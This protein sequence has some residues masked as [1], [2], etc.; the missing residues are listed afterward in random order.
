MKF[1]LQYL[2]I[3]T[4]ILTSCTKNKNEIKVQPLHNPVTILG[5]QYGTVTIGKLTWTTENYNGASGMN[6]A[7]SSKNDPVYG[8]LYTFREAIAIS[9]PAG[10]RVPTDVDYQFLEAYTNNNAPNDLEAKTNLMA[11]TTWMLGGTN[12]LKFNAV[13]AGYFLDGAYVGKG[14]RTA[15]ICTSTRPISLEYKPWRSFEISEDFIV[16]NLYSFANVKINY[17]VKDSSAIKAATDRGSIRFV[18]NND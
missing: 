16:P 6:Y 12:N 4:I 5:T 1:P 3:I 8:K 13:A 14:E 17:G 15:F 9:L 7:N 11:N 2:I 18:K 10:W